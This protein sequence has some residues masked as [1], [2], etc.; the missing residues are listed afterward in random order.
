[1]FSLQLFRIFAI[2]FVIQMKLKSLIFFL[3]IAVAVTAQTPVNISNPLTWTTDDLRSYVGQT[4]VFDVPFYVTNNYSDSYLE[5]S[6]RRVFVPTN[7]A[8]PGTTE[9]SSIVL[10]NSDAT[11]KLY[12]VNDYHRMGEKLMGLTVKVTSSTSVTLSGTPVFQGNTREDLERGHEDI[13]DYNVK[14]CT[15]NLEYYLV[16]NYGDG[17][18]PDNAT[19]ANRQHQKLLNALA[20]VDADIYGLVEIE[21]GQA[22]LSKMASA[23]TS[24]LGHPFSYVNDGGSSSG[25]YTKVGYI[26]RSDKIETYGQLQNI[27]NP[28]P[29]H[30][31]KTLAFQLKANGE[32]FIFSLNHFKAKSGTGT[33]QDADQG[34]GQGVFNYT[35]TREAEAVVRTLTSNISYFDDPDVLIMGDLNAYAKEDPVQTLVEAGYT[36]LHRAFH[37]DSSYSYTYRGQAGYLDHALASR[38][39]LEQVTGMTA[40]H[41][42]SDE[43][44]DYTYDKSSDVTMF[45]SSDHDPI[46]VGLSLGEYRDPDASAFWENVEYTTHVV[47]TDEPFELRNAQGAYLRIYSMWG[48]L[49][50]SD[51]VETDVY[52]LNYTMSSGVYV[53]NLY[54]DGEV[55]QLKLIVR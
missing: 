38:S 15:M 29:L 55:K 11:V 46:I 3:W 49:V 34:D 52:T 28:S 13:G 20:A 31:K 41:I 24:R 35:R 14:V 39:M 43:Q 12:G 50:Y 22:A 5:I 47:S 53:V 45:R 37:A 42:N 8:F 17:F 51:R 10:A 33:G 27:D 23:L 26:Y 1:M 54:G 4:V 21:Q 16:E 40:Y 19:Q 9:Y 48:T 25:S 7:Q 30:R 18:G 44:D 6:P 2:L 36:D 32:K